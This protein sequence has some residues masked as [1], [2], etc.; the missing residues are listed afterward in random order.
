MQNALQQHCGRNSLRDLE[1]WETFQHLMARHYHTERSEVFIPMMDFVQTSAFTLILPVV[2]RTAHLTAQLWECVVCT[3]P[4]HYWR[5][6]EFRSERSVFNETEHQHAEQGCDDRMASAQT[7][8]YLQT[9][10]SKSKSEGL[11]R[12]VGTDTAR[13]RT[14]ASSIARQEQAS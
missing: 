8:A 4:V 12:A 6:Y 7:H 13:M 1:L 11:S 9:V 5:H 2:Q 14:E 3:N 10:R